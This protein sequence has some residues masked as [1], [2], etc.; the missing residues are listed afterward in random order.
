MP[1]NSKLVFFDIDGTLLNDKKTI[2]QSTISTINKLQK[3]NFSFCIAT[4]RGL[5]EGIIDLANQLSLTDYLVLA[6][7]NYVWDIKNQKLTTL[8]SPISSNVIL[9]LVDQAKK[10]KRQLNVFYE[11]GTIKYFYFGDNINSDIKDAKFFVIGPMIYNF[12]NINELQDDLNNKSI[13]HIGIKAES[14]VIKEIYS[15]FL[16]TDFSNLVKI[17]TVSDIFLEV[18]SLGVSKWL[19]IQFVQR[20]LN[21]SNEDTYAFGD[22]LNDLDMLENVGNPICMG[23]SDQLLKDKIKVIIGDNNSDAIS[24][25]LITLSNKN[26]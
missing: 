24:D 15:N 6:N 7:G 14:N 8:G 4:G 23:N 3:E 10:Y 9:W 18:E 5:T 17:S 20:R 1:N 2:N 16:N 22:S 11:D 21:I 19:G 25:F 26:A 13:V 12:S